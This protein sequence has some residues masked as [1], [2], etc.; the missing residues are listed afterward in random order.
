MMRRGA[1][2]IADERGFTLSE[3]V[4]VVALV[5]FLL[6][7]VVT[8]Q[9]QGQQAYLFGAARVQ[10]QQNAR[11]GLATLRDELRSARSITSAA[12]CNN[13]ASGASAITFVDQTGTA[14]TYQLTGTSLQRTTGAGTVT[15]IGGVETLNV[16]CYLADGVSLTAS[17]ALVASVHVRLTTRDETIALRHQHAIV[18]TRVRLRNV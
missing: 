6:A 1:A 8:I 12:S 17:A 4:I 15:L 13:A 10:A 3:L 18:E 9:Q 14:V 16:W 5:G 7:G 2:V 11:F